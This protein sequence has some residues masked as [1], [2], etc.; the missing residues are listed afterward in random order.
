MDAKVCDRCKKVYPHK[1]GKNIWVLNEQYPNIGTDILVRD[2]KKVIDLCPECS[3]ELEKWFEV[4][5]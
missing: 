4:V 5:E 3:A 2:A 1:T